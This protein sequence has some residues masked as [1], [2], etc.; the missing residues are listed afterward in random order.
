MVW[1]DKDGVWLNQGQ[2]LFLWNYYSCL[3]AHT[4]FF[5]SAGRGGFLFSSPFSLLC[6]FVACLPSSFPSSPTNS[7]K[8]TLNPGQTLTPGDVF[9]RGDEPGRVRSE[10]PRPEGRG[11]SGH[12]E[13]WPCSR[14][15]R[16]LVGVARGQTLR[17]LALPPITASSKLSEAGPLLSKKLGG[18]GGESHG[19][20]RESSFGRRQGLGPLTSSPRGFCENL[21]EQGG[22]GG[23]P[24]V[25]T[26]NR[27]G[28][29]P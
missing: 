22:W 16:V 11:R 2:V 15:R 9:K 3:T 20:E 28:L 7:G 29:A 14:R 6:P 26:V 1:G 18:W 13:G 4:P 19:W 21:N 12:K 5:L 23:G 17:P 8:H 24:V 10:V 27:P 25:R